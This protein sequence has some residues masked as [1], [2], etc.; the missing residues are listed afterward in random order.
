MADRA[1]NDDK[2]KADARV[3]PPRFGRNVKRPRVDHALELVEHTLDVMAD[4]DRLIAVA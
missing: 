1:D 2:H 3:T 4:I